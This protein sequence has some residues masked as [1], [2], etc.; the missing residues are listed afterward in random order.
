[1]LI[2]WLGEGEM[3]EVG[4]LMSDVGGSKWFK[5]QCCS[6]F[7]V[8]QGSMLFKIVQGSRLF[9]GTMRLIK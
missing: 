7:N 4:G 6:R 1:M 9:K 2:G 3:L 8:V 5:V